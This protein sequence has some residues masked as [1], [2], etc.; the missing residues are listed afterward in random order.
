MRPAIRGL[1]SQISG[2]N[3][4]R[5]RCPDR[6]PSTLVLLPEARA[7]PISGR[8]QIPGALISHPV[9][10]SPNLAGGSGAHRG[11]SATHTKPCTV[12]SDPPAPKGPCRV[13]RLLRDSE[14]HAG[15]PGS[16]SL[17]RV[18]TPLGD[19][20]SF[21]RKSEMFGF[22]GSPSSCVSGERE[23]VEIKRRHRVW[24]RPNVAMR[25]GPIGM[26]GW[27]PE[28]RRQQSRGGPCS[29]IRWCV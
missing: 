18:G 2:G 13:A 8:P 20:I 11:N 22:V 27:R 19:P 24:P 29:A 12:P 28:E 16:V 3:D 4:K 7:D 6:S 9:E 23:A 26:P 21:L 5:V 10:R 1:T 15:Q 25:E 14:R 17:G